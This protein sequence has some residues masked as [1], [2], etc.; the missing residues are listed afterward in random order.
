MGH[1]DTTYTSMA[2][3]AHTDSSYF[4]DPVGLLQFFHLL[5][6]NGTG[7]TSLYVDD[8]FKVAIEL[9]EKEPWAFDALV[10]DRISIQTNRIIKKTLMINEVY[11]FKP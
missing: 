3:G 1:G 8:G 9:Q 4:T 10:Q 2:L 11:Y 7:G 5:E 6:H